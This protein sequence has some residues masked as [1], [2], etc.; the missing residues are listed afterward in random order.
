VARAYSGTHSAQG[1][2][3]ARLNS[4]NA[5]LTGTFAEKLHDKRTESDLRSPQHQGRFKHARALLRSVII[6]KDAQSVRLQSLSGREFQACLLYLRDFM[7]AIDSK[8]VLT[9]QGL[10]KH[11]NDLAHG[12]R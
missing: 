8:D 9:I 12:L 4:N 1:G 2:R 3:Y 11:R 6:T 7:K 5:I 10:R